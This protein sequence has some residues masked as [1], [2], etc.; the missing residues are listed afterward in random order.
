MRI[1]DRNSGRQTDILKESITLVHL[2]LC[3]KLSVCEVL[4]ERLCWR[5]FHALKQ[6]DDLPRVVEMPLVR[7]RTVVDYLLFL[8]VNHQKVPMLFTAEWNEHKLLLF[9]SI[10][11]HICYVTSVRFNNVII[12]QTVLFKGAKVSR[13]KLI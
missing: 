1:L 4:D 2:L 12:S 5:A 3:W 8:K 13:Q 11:L 7:D 6:L 10:L 9:P